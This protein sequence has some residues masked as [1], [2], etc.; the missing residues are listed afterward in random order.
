MNTLLIFRFFFLFIVTTPFIIQANCQIPVD[1]KNEFERAGDYREAVLEYQHSLGSYA[2]LFSGTTYSFNRKDTKGHPFIY[3]DSWQTGDVFIY[4]RV[5]FDIEMKLD[6]Y[7][8]VLLLN[9]KGARNPHQAIILNDPSLR[10][11]VLSGRFFIKIQTQEADSLKVR[12]GYY[13]LVYH[14][15]STVLVKHRKTIDSSLKFGTDLHEEYVS[16]A[17][18]FLIINGKAS[19]INNRKALVKALSKH[20][21]AIKRFIKDNRIKYSNQK[22]ENIIKVVRFYDSLDS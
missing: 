8:D 13:E 19:R 17:N 14:E 9:H 22:L 15:K 3:T 5:F 7:N 21:A 6:I 12:E 1:L 20:N 18:C 2:V 16:D 10:G 11:G 4:D